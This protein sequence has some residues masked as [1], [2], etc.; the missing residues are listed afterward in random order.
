MATD[1]TTVTSQKYALARHTAS[2]EVGAEPS[3]SGRRSIGTRPGLR[4]WRRAPRELN[5]VIKCS[6]H[7]PAVF[8]TVSPSSSV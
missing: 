2:K 6:M 8:E 7:E 1:E 4:N 3:M 5:E